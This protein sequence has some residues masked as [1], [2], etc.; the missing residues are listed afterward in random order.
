MGQMYEIPRS[1]GFGDGTVGPQQAAQQAEAMK[2][3]GALGP[4]PAPIAMAPIPV[5]PPSAAG[6]MSMLPN[7]ANINVGQLASQLQQQA[8]QLPWWVWLAGGV[9]VGSQFFG[10]K[11]G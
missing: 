11:K 1:Q 3:A 6:P 2:Q 4:P 7:L 8:S 10:K 5:A 9:V